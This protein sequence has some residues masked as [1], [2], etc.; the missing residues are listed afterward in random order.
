MNKKQMF[1]SG[2]ICGLPIALPVLLSL[3]WMKP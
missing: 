1:L 3:L 2:V